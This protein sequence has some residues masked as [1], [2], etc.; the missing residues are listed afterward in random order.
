MYTMYYFVLLAVQ[1][2]CI[3][4]IIALRPPNDFETTSQV[5]LSNSN[6][7]FRDAIREDIDDITTVILDAFSQGLA[8]QYVRPEYQRFKDYTWHC[9][10]AAFAKQWND[11]NT[12]TTFVKVVTVPDTSKSSKGRGERVV[13][14]GVWLRMARNDTVIPAMESFIPMLQ[15]SVSMWKGQMST[16]NDG[17]N[18]NCSAILD[19][20]QTRVIDIERQMQAVK[21]KYID[22]A[23]PKQLHLNMLAT[24]PDW[25]GNGFAALN[26]D[27]GVRF[28]KALGEPVTLIAT[29]DGYVLYDDFG[30]RSLK[31]VTIKTLEGWEE[32]SLWFEVMQYL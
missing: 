3:K 26:L 8:W 1:I 23:Y 17:T 10:R 20:N 12:N 24:H 31:N 18:Y 7:K 5:I 32:E 27:W 16:S 25:D 15:N 21:L 19:V 14:L 22:D 9:T 30:F 29:P 6:Y 11:I 13:A 28:A 2:L 4:S